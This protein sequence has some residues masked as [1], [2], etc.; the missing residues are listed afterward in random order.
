MKANRKM[1][2]NNDAITSYL[3]IMIFTAITVMLVIIVWLFHSG[4]LSEAPKK[5]TPSIGMIQDGDHVFI[6][7]VRNG[8]VLNKSVYAEI[9]NKSTGESIG[10]ASI[11]DGGDGEVNTGDS[12]IL[13]GI[14]KGVFT[15]SIYYEAAIIGHCQY[16]IY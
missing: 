6:T 9:I 14:K 13:T 15:V 10:E 5:L 11:N 8:P 12:I 2:E 4:I 1:I 3:S 16:S 7:S